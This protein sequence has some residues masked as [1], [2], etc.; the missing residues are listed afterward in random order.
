MRDKSVIRA[1]VTTASLA[2]PLVSS[3]TEVGNF[4]LAGKNLLASRLK[5]SWVE[6]GTKK[7]K[8]QN[9]PPQKN[10]ITIFFLL[11]RPKPFSDVAQKKT[12]KKTSFSGQI[13]AFSNLIFRFFFA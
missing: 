9:I 12:A 1:L 10:A 3:T 8:L 5:L 2:T 13:C 7:S 4:G 6:P 11:L